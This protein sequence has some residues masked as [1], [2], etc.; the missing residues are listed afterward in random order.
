MEGIKKI[1]PGESKDYELHFASIRAMLVEILE[2]LRGHPEEEEKY[3]IEYYDGP[4][5]CS[6]YRGMSFMLKS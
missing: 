2:L 1:R 6:D 5:R 4:C 3:I